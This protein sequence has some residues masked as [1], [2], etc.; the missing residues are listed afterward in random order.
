M[1]TPPPPPLPPPPPSPR[2]AMVTA[3]TLRTSLFSFPW[4]CL[5]PARDLCA[6]KRRREEGATQAGS[7]PF[8]QSYVLPFAAKRGNMCKYARTYPPMLE[9]EE[10]RS[11][12]EKESCRLRR[13]FLEKKGN[14]FWAKRREEVGRGKSAKTDPPPLPQTYAHTLS[15]SCSLRYALFI[16]RLSRQARGRFPLETEGLLFWSCPLPLQKKSS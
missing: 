4:R 15:P 9:L 10:E 16:C 5:L 13:P 3:C 1:K 6:R 7:P 11:A 12:R 8:P 2:H 14:S